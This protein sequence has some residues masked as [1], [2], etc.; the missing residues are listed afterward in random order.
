MS[1]LSPNLLDLDRF[2][3]DVRRVERRW[4]YELIYG[5]TE[6]YCGKILFVR[7][8]QE[9]SPRFHRM[10]DEVIYLQEGRLELE[11]GEPGRPPDSEVVGPGR[12]F[13]L[14]PG[15]VHGLRALE[16]S[17]VLE[18]STP[19]LDDVVSLESRPERAG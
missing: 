12:A 1:E 13:R 17:L 14:A 11:I 15:T 18:V 6:R 10:K 9:V 2:S 4:G 5:A 16:D 8:G 7:K 3:L 19:E